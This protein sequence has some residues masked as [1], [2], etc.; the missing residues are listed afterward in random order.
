MEKLY[1][2]DQNVLM[3]ISLLKQNGIRKV[4]VSPG[5]ANILLVASLQHDG[6]FEMYSDVDE[7][8]AAY[9]A[10]G[11]AYESQEPVVL[12]CTGA[13]AS[14]NYFSGLTEA[15][16]RKLP[17][18]A[19]TSGSAE[20]YPDNLNP[21]YIDRSIQPRDIVRYSTKL[22]IISSENDIIDSNIKINRAIWELKKDGG[23][24][25]HIDLPTN[26]RGKLTERYLPIARC[27]H[28]YSYGDK[29][30]FI[31]DNMRIAITV[32]AHTRWSER[33]IQAVDKFCEFYH[34]PVIYENSSGYRGKYGIRPTVLA[35]Q[36]L[37]VSNNFNPD[38]LIHI[39]NTVGDVYTN[40]KLTGAKEVWRVSQDGRIRDSF[41]KLKNNFQMSEEYFFDIYNMY[42]GDRVRPSYNY[43]KEFKE[44]AV[45]IY[46]KF[47]EIPFSSIWISKKISDMIPDNSNV[48]LG[49]GNVM[50]AFNLFEYKENVNVTAN[51]GGWGIDGALSTGL[52]IS[53]VDKTKNTYII[54]GDLAFFY[55]LN[56]LGNRFIDKNLRIL[57]INNGKGVEM[58][59]HESGVQ[60]N[61]GDLAD[62]FSA[63]GGHFGNQSRKL[64]KHFAEDLN[65]DYI[66]ANNEA[67]F[68]NCI[69]KFVNP[70]QTNKP[71]IFEV[72][73]TDANEREA[74]YKV[75]NILS[76][77]Q[78]VAKKKLIKILGKTGTEMAIK[79]RDNI[80]NI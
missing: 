55:D 4:V 5:T 53:Q 66:S 27:I 2:S 54:L 42:C 19:I 57:L 32:G 67:E 30:P 40:R 6:E 18:L 58:R 7:R 49:I 15:Y 62:S 72:F 43:Y 31:P 56:C 34:A 9:F 16:Y 12:T 8:G 37:H 59:I 36:E 23:G 26:W 76:D 61:L 10:C 77:T 33:L 17:I 74:W 14:R 70:Q 52:G 65:F 11:L 3:I 48:H 60:K 47:P 39:G 41:G 38:L 80:K 44:E 20:A 68:L 45:N 25:V 29:L 46:N 21:Q 64:V 50:R 24:P 69:D 79:I 71:L 1:S 78:Q 13:T 63:A 28:N 73:T 51:T 75:C 22:N 35:A